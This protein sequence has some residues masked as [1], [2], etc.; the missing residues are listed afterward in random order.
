MNKHQTDGVSLAFGSIFLVI[1]TW[2][3]LIRAIDMDLP[4]PVGSSPP[5]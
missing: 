1:V 4:A 5:G 3:L 2:W